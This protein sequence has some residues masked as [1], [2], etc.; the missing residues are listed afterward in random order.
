MPITITVV[1][2]TIA[3]CY[4]QI[5]TSGTN[6]ATVEEL[7]LELRSRLRPQGLVVNID[8]AE[9]PADD[10]VAAE[11]EAV[12]EAVEE[13]IPATPAPDKPK[14]GR[15]RIVRET[16]ETPTEKA[17][18]TGGPTRDEVIAALNAFAAARGGQVAARQAMQETCGVSRLVDVKAEDYGKLLARL[19]A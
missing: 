19:K 5:G 11:T 15:P 6:G 8:P 2:E 1:G 10:D 16:A 9:E 3:E 17:A 14:R 18:T 12:A 7:V 13:A 4:R